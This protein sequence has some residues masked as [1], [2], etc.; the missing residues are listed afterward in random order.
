MEVQF[1]PSQM[2]CIVHQN[3]KI[4]LNNTRQCTVSRSLIISTNMFIIRKTTSEKPK[5]G[6]IS[7]RNALKSTL[8]IYDFNTFLQ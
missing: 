1:C 2:L 6:T 4:Y 8:T 7:Q 3:H 5:N